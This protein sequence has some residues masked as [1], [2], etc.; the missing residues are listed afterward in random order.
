MFQLQTL[1]LDYIRPRAESGGLSLTTGDE[2][3]DTE[4]MESS[5]EFILTCYTLPETNMAPLNMMFGRLQ[6][7]SGRFYVCFVIQGVY[8]FV[9]EQEQH[10][11]TFSPKTMLLC[12]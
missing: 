2:L 7:L 10:D 3:F 6:S 12:H 5:S 4:D 8:M 1:F 11:A 9:E